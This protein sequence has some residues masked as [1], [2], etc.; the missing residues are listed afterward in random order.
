GIGNERVLQYIFGENDIRN[1][2]IFDLLNMQTGDWE[3]ARNTERSPLEM[4]AVITSAPEVL[5]A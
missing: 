1:V 3:V 2:S 4:P 5:E